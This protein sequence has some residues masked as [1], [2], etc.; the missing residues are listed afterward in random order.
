[1]SSCINQEEE[2]AAH[3]NDNWWASA[4]YYLAVKISSGHEYTI[5][6]SSSAA[7]T[8][9]HCGADWVCWV[10]P[11]SRF[12]LSLLLRSRSGVTGRNFHPT[13]IRPPPVSRARISSRQI[14]PPPPPPPP[15]L[16]C[17]SLSVYVCLYGGQDDWGEL[18]ILNRPD[19]PAE[20]RLLQ[21]RPRS[22]AAHF[23][24]RRH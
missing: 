2:E 18:L 8:H 3:Q 13:N 6:M 7:S 21:F 11:S 24:Y 16:L 20:S 12:R 23:L 9:R 22:A 1:M 14:R 10:R 4:L 19:A 5:V 17:L 15:H